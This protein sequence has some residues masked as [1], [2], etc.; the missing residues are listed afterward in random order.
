[1]K[2]YGKIKIS[3]GEIT[4]N[5]EILKLQKY[6]INKVLKEVKKRNA[7]RLKEL[8]LRSIIVKKFNYSRNKKVDNKNKENLLAQIL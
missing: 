8:G 4:N 3:T 5:D 7:R 6:W 1:M 2:K